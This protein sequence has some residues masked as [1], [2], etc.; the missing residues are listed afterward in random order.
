MKPCPFKDL[1]LNV[2][3]SLTHNSMEFGKKNPQNSI[4]RWIGKNYGLF[5][6]WN[7]TQNKRDKLLCLVALLTLSGS[8]PM[9]KVRGQKWKYILY[10]WIYEIL[11]HEKLT[12]SDNR[13]MVIWGEVIR[14]WGV[15][16]FLLDWIQ[17]GTREILGGMKKIL[18]CA[19]VC[20]LYAFVKP[21]QTVFFSYA[22]YTWIKLI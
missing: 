8:L 9:L 13:S 22:N 18:Y 20:K 7:T 10:V 6:Q 19:V 5:K 2:H 12:Y 16:V 1:Y 14:F 21:H 17:R 15:F 4:H 3:K 11:E